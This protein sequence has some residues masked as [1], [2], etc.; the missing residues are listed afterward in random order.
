LF[1]SVRV[2]HPLRIDDF[3]SSV[4]HPDFHKIINKG[5]AWSGTAMKGLQ[6]SG[7]RLLQQPRLGPIE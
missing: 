2:D 3:E 5:T 7:P 4:A 6:Q 1:G